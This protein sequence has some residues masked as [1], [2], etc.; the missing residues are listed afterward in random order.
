[1][2]LFRPKEILDIFTDFDMSGYRD[3]GFDTVLLDI[4]NTIAV[5]NTGGCDERARKFIEELKEHGYKVVI[6]SNNSE[7]RVRMFLSDMDV[8]YHYLA[9]KPLPFSYLYMCRK[10]GTSPSRTVVLGDQLMTDILGANLSGCC[11]IYCRQLQEKDSKMTAFNRRIEKFI[12]RNILHEE[13]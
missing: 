10:M 5:P 6:F 11:G 12:W 13:M 2:A 3:R 8:D 1:M 4:D 9:F 7:D